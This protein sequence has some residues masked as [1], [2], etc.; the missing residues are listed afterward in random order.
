MCV[1]IVSNPILIIIVRFL[2]VALC[3]AT[4]KLFRGL[5]GIGTMILMIDQSVLC[6]MMLGGKILVLGSM[7]LGLL[8]NV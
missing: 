5:A 1:D 8:G 7:V 3:D 6:W 2:G 4:I